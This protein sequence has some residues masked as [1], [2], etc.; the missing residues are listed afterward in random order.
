VLVK[1]IFKWQERVKFQEA[2][3]QNPQSP[4]VVFTVTEQDFQ[5]T[6]TGTHDGY[7]PL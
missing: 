2:I 3:Q 1:R 4:F 6:K 7:N 5:E